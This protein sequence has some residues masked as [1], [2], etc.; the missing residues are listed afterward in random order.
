MRV[1]AITLKPLEDKVEYGVTTE[2]AAEI[3]TNQ[4]NPQTDW[5]IHG[6]QIPFSLGA[7]TTGQ[8]V[9]EA[10]AVDAISKGYLPAP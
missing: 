9:L 6:V 2:A 10:C 1:R 4:L 3:P 8:E 7:E 5:V